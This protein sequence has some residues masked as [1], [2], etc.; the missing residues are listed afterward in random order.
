MATSSTSLR[1]PNHLSTNGKHHDPERPID[2]RRG[3]EGS[4]QWFNDWSVET[5]AGRGTC[6][7]GSIANEYGEPAERVDEEHEEHR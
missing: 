3:M 5:D 6:I 4:D 7:R 1:V 2:P